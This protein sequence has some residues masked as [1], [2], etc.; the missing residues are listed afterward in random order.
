MTLYWLVKYLKDDDLV[1][2]DIKPMKSFPKGESLMLSFC[3]LDPI[4]ESKLKRYDDSLTKQKYIE[5]LSGQRD[6][7][8]I[9]KLDVDNVTLNLT[10]FLLSDFTIL[11]NGSAI[12]GTYPNFAI[13]LPGVTYSWIAES[14]VSKCFGLRS[15]YKDVHFTNFGF[16]SSV[17]PKGIRSSKLF[18]AAF[19]LSNKL[20]I[21]EANAEIDNWPERQEKEG[22]SMTF[23]LQQIEILERRNKRNDPCLADGLKYDQISLGNH[24]YEI[25]FRAP[26]QKTSKEL[27]ICESK[28]ELKEANSF[29][30]SINEPCTILATVTFTYNEEKVDSEE[31]DPDVF[32]VNIIFPKH[33][34]EIKMVKAIDIHTAIG[35]SG[36]YIGLFLGKRISF[37]DNCNCVYNTISETYCY[38]FLFL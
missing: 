32:D 38:N 5:I 24:L 21:S 30:D 11:R 23:T 37:I 14:F 29:P 2:V 35:N 6:Y 18:T 8:G 3:F 27:K 1:Q 20:L 22:Y 31:M 13:E 19:H 26:Y 9:E 15:K 28:E 33:F 10:N 7:M 16:N 12:D 34:K 36:G 4:I 25:G 17:F